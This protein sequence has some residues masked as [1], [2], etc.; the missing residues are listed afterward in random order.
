[1][2]ISEL[3]KDLNETI[4]NNKLNIINNH[5][6]YVKN[7]IDN[8]NYLVMNFMN[9]ELKK[10]TVCYFCKCNVSLGSYFQHIQTKAHK[11][12]IKKFLEE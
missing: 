3:K 8:I 9:N 6:N 7:E 10:N 1:M 5:Y 2:E 12:N 4:L 11:N